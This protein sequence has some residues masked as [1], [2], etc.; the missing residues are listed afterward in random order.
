V[1]VARHSSDPDRFVPGGDV[2]VGGIRFQIEQVRSSADAAVLKLAS[3]DTEDDAEALRGAVVEV[4]ASA[5]PE[6][7]TGTYYHYQ[8]IGA[9]VVTTEGEDLGTVA[10][11]LETG[12][13]DVYVVRSNGHEVLVPALANVIVRVDVDHGVIEVDLPEGLR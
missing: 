7:P 4:D 13:N 5:L 9:R 12:S 10:E 1:V 6:P 2:Y 3:V 11:I 8:I